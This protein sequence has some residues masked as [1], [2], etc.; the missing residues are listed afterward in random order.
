M[1]NKLALKESQLC[2]QIASHSGVAVLTSYQSAHDDSREEHRTFTNVPIS[3]FL[4]AS[5]ML[6]M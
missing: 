3:L 4:T 6:S 1:C 2:H 5:H